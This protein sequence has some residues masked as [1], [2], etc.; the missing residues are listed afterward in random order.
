MLIEQGAPLEA[1]DDV[2]FGTPLHTAVYKG[3][4]EMLQLL[5]A[6]GEDKDS[7]DI[8]GYKPL[9]LAAKKGHHAFAEALLAAGADASIRC[10]RGV[11]LPLTWLLSLVLSVLI[12]HGVDVNDAPWQGTG[13][14]L[15]YA[16]RG[17]KADAIDV[18]AAAGAN[19]EARNEDEI[20]P[21]HLA[22]KLF[23][24]GS[25]G[26]FTQA[27]RAHQRAGCAWAHA[28][29]HSSRRSWEARCGGDGGSSAEVGG[30]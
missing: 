20:T 23:C 16:T 27:P 14:A 12:R 29:A 25:C 17:N 9:K 18:L 19:T 26:C 22:G 6:G 15:H 28:A 7:W 13:T 5:V 11:S 1:K 30:G 8:G 3:N 24:G 2:N 10:R 21:L 4:V